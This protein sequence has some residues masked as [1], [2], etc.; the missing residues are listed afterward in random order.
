MGDGEHRD[1]VTGRLEP[2]PDPEL[3]FDIQTI[4]GPDGQR[5][6]EQQARVMREVIEWLAR[7]R[8]ERGRDNAA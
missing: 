2:V 4:D 6:A 7:T 3:V 1:E 5:L 8:S